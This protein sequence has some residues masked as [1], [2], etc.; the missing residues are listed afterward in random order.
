MPAAPALPRSAAPR[1][2]P[3]LPGQV[4]RSLRAVVAIFLAVGFLV[5]GTP[6]TASAA[7]PITISAKVLLQGHARVGSWMAIQVEL[8]NSGPAVKGELRLSGG[9]S[10]RTR[11]SVPVDL[12][13]TARQAYLL[14]AQPPSF[15]R[16]VKVELVAGDKT[17]ASADA[18]FLAHDPSQLVIGILAE[19][20]DGIIR[21]A[22]PRPRRERIGTGDRLAWRG[23]PPGSPR[24]LGH[25]GPPDLAG[26]RQQHDVAGAAQR[27]AGLDRGRR[28]SRHRRW[29]GRHRHPVGVPGRPPA[30]PSRR[31]DRCRPCQPDRT[32]RPA[33]RQRGRC[34]RV[35][36]YADLR[37]A[38]LPARATR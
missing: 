6:R 17:I 34:P 31:D 19:K 24:G 15:G 16:S 22:Q 12:P 27:D 3:E 26:R 8:S 38:P 18:G 36:G 30:V 13:T 25:P 32:R 9:A 21:R 33:T 37:P 2:Q 10:G 20:P 28:P 11:F 35:R 29:D 14:H 7:G 4:Q 5:G 23:R 1:R